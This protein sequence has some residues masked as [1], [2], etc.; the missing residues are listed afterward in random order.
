MLPP[1]AAPQEPTRVFY[2]PSHDNTDAMKIGA[3]FDGHVRKWCVPRLRAWC[4]A[5]TQPFLVTNRTR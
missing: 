1:R 4:F 2:V 3:R 5:R